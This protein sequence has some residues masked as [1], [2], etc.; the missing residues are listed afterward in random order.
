MRVIVQWQDSNNLCQ[1]GQNLGCELPFYH[2]E[3]ADFAIP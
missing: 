2:F 1:V 3:N